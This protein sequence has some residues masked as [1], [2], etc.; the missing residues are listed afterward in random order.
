MIEKPCFQNDKKKMYKNERI[1]Y[2]K[3]FRHFYSL[4][5]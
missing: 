5:I 3:R 4:P 1:M 2:P